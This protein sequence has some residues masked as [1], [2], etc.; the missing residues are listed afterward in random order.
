MDIVVLGAWGELIGG[1]G[2]IASLIF[3]GFQVRHSAKAS[4]AS[5]E[6]SKQTEK[7]LMGQTFQARSDA[8]QDLSM[9]LAESAELSSIRQR[10]EAAGFPENRSAV[11]Q[12]TPVER[13]QYRHFLRAHL[14]R[15]SNLVFQR[16]QGLLDDD[17]WE[18]MS[19]PL[20]R[21]AVMW[22]AFDIEYRAGGRLGRAMEDIISRSPPS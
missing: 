13:E 21:F 3:V 9:R 10:L 7:M 15:M 2:V 16:Q 17:Y 1:V 22:E 6:Q 14:H 19:Q 12:L 20:R 4:E 8:L 18:N 5:I 11:D